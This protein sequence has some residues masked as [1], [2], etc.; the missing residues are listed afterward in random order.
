MNAIKSRY[1]VQI[2]EKMQA[3]I[4]EEFL[5]SK[6][7]P[8]EEAED[9]AACFGFLGRGAAEGKEGKDPAAVK[10][11]ALSRDAKAAGQRGG[12]AEGEKKGDDMGSASSCCGACADPE[13]VD[14]TDVVKMV[15]P[16]DVVRARQLRTL[17]AVVFNLGC[18]LLVLAFGMKFDLDA[19]TG[20]SVRAFRK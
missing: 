19:S 16:A 20:M 18:G 2:D 5:L 11:S 14:F 8:Q 4:Q 13:V 12:A 3:K 7:T 9:G 17:F 6:P 15:T 10:P 1:F